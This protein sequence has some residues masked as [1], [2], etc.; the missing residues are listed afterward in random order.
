MHRVF[1]SIILFSFLGVSFNAA[2]QYY[3]Y[4]QD[5]A[6]L[7]WRQIRTDHFRFIYPEGLENDAQK[8]TQFFET[9][10]TPVSSSLVSN[11]KPIPVILRNQTMLSNGFVMWAPKRIEMVTTIPYDNQAVDWMRYLAVHE[12]RH[13]VQ[14]EAVNRSTTRSFSNIFGQHITGAVAGAHLPLWFLEG[15]AVL[16]ETSLSK[17]GRGRLPS[18]YF[19]LIAQV[20]E[21]GVYSYDK[22]T[23]G[24]YRDIVPNHYVL[25]YHIV[26][27]TQANFGFEPFQEA[28]LR[29]AK[30]PILPGSFSR[31]LKSTTGFRAG[32]LYDWAILKLASEWDSALNSMP[33]SSLKIISPETSSDYCSYFS[34]HYI[35][36]SQFIAFRVKPADIPRLILIDQNGNEKVLFTPGFGH[37]ETMSYANGMVAWAE[38]NRD[39]RWA[40][41]TYTDIRIFNLN[42]GKATLITKKG[43]YQSP[44]LSPDG[45]QLVAIELDET[46][47]WDLVV[48]NT[49]SGKVQYRISDPGIGFLM[50]PTWDEDGRHII[51]IAFTEG[52][53]KSLVRTSLTNP[54]FDELLNAGEV[55]IFNP[56]VRNNNVYFTGTWSGRNEIYTMDMNSA[57]LYRL[58]PTRFG[59]SK[60]VGSAN[61]SRLVISDLTAT[62][63]KIAEIQ[64]D[65][66]EKIDLESLPP[67]PFK[68]FD[69]AAR[70]EN[71]LIENVK[72][73]NVEFT[74]K[75]FN[76]FFNHLH[77]H[78]WMPAALDVDQLNALP[79]ISFLSQDLLGTTTF[80]AGY[81]YENE[82]N[83]HKGFVDYS[84]QAWYPVVDIRLEG[85]AEDRFYY[86][87]DKDTVISLRTTLMNAIAG[88][89]LPLSFNKHATIFGFAPRISTTQEFYTFEFA[90]QTFK[91]GRRPVS[92]RLTGYA[93]QRMAY[94]DLFPKY[95]I[96]GVAGFRHT[97]FRASKSFTDVDA[98]NIIYAA[99]S[100]FLPGMVKHHSLRLYLGWQ[101]KNYGQTY[102]GDAIRFARGYEAKANDE[103]TI[104]SLN[105]SFPLLYPDKSLGSL[106]YAKRLKANIFM[107]YSILSYK[108]QQTGLFTYGV[109]ILLDA[110]LFKMPMPFEFGVRAMYLESIKEVGFEF[111]WGVDF[112][113]LGSL[114]NLRNPFIKSGF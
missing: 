31:G 61:G 77:F 68:L 54:G 101:K 58:S 78:S 40:Y 91:R 30:T 102:F 21:K 79:G 109:D 47:K 1:V 94:R 12:Y 52:K 72:E 75:P 104:T 24:S 9:I 18:F 38:I 3:S 66:L 88:V 62:G 110:H 26:A 45:S 60:P 69:A 65:N 49:H 86:N 17:S 51:A 41:R 16:S 55:D 93:Y 112:Y 82:V 56:F 27:T 35:N 7:K 44:K 105:Y 80:S 108:N 28:T 53:G 87:R 100:V 99:A 33:A 50:E 5:P 29:V 92:Y 84:I 19:P 2:A 113:S 8:L 97:P 98:G 96:S 85:G 6:S 39:P 23:L 74:S 10:R 36:D 63:Q 107:D 83:G 46:N 25:G 42:T 71:F 48:L 37:Y 114:L 14:I 11:P 32:R 103:L 59:S 34:P 64:T 73:E 95:G 4:G 81:T 57:A 76:K 43:R 13:V 15:D 111:L 70:E 89:S 106:I 22:A 90:D 67:N 20:L